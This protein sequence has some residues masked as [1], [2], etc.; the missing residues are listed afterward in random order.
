MAHALYSRYAGGRDSLPESHVAGASRRARQRMT[1]RT[2]RPAGT[3]KT[4]KTTTQIPMVASH[5]A[6]A[7]AVSSASCSVCP[8][9]QPDGEG[10]AGEL[11]PV[12]GVRLSVIE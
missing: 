9:F 10:V 2:I 11:G 7:S 6:N 5:S 4:L 12:V 3:T 1:S 8:G